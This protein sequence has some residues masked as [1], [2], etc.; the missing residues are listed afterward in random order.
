[1]FHSSLNWDVLLNVPNDLYFLS[2][3]ISS[4]C[5]FF[6]HCISVLYHSP[7]VHF[8]L[9]HSPSVHHL[10][11][12]PSVPVSFLI[13]FVPHVSFYYP[14]VL[15]VLYWLVILNINFCNK[16]HPYFCKLQNILHNCSLSQVVHYPAHAN[17]NGRASLIGLALVSR[18]TK[19]LDC[20]VIPLLANAD[21]NGVELLKWKH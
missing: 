8:F 11:H 2:L 13:T 10:Y 5:T 15:L 3:L 20:S 18:K 6:K 12:S 16:E 19:L 7:S 9:Y 4:P 14:I 17:S 21:H 1:M